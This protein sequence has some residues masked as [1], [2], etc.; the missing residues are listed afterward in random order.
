[1]VIGVVGEIRR[2]GV[3][4]L[5]SPTWA[6]LMFLATPVALFFLMLGVEFLSRGTK[7]VP[8]LIMWLGILVGFCVLLVAPVAVAVT[9]VHALIMNRRQAGKPRTPAADSAG[10]L[11]P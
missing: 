8:E 11:L 9:L 10:P 3:K 2:R 1:M 4:T 5:L 6:L 7:S